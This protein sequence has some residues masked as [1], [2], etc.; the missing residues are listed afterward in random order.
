MNECFHVNRPH[1]VA[2]SLLVK[3]GRKIARKKIEH[4]PQ[5]L[6]YFMR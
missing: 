6:L 1:L 5:A 3:M 2:E 4:F